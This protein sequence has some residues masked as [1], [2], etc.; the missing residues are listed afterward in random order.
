M[1]KNKYFFLFD[2]GCVCVCIFE[3]KTQ[4]NKFH[5]TNTSKWGVMLKLVIWLLHFPTLIKSRIVWLRLIPFLSFDASVEI[6]QC[7]QVL[8]LHVFGCMWWICK[9]MSVFWC[10]KGGLF[11]RMR[12]NEKL[13]EA[14]SKKNIQKFWW[15]IQNKWPNY[16][17]L[18]IM[19][20]CWIFT[21]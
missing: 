19:D 15:I 3:P 20:K 1:H 18:K 5:Q 6:R 2:V 17:K 14:M 11:C 8:T 12:F 10:E 7:S 4:G 13:G 21:F 16:W 9:G